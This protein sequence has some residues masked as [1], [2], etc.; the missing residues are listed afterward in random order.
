MLNG[1]GRKYISLTADCITV[2]QGSPVPDADKSGQEFNYLVPIIQIADAAID[3][4]NVKAYS[5]WYDGYDH[6]SL[7][8][9]QDVYLNWRNLQGMCKGC[10]P[11]PGFKGVAS[12]KLLMGVLASPDAR[13]SSEY[14]TPT[15]VRDF[16]TWLASKGYD[17]YGL[18]LWNS[19]W[20]RANGNQISQAI[21]A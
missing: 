4:Y 6:N 11:I 8:Y 15:T 10:L 9:L 19:Y 21:L 17:L 7:T 2:Y 13:A 12:N 1:L 20:D 18:Q 14:K 5:N 3:F 16:K